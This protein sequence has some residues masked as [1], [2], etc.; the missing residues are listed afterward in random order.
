MTFIKDFLKENGMHSLPLAPF[1]GSRFNILFHNAGIVYFFHEKMVTFLKDH[2]SNQWVLHDLKISFFVAGCKALGLICKL[3]TSPLWNLI[4]KKDIHIMDMN[5][6][7]LQLTTFLNDASNNLDDFM[8]G[9]ILPFG[10]D[11]YVK[12]D[13]VYQKL[14]TPIEYDGETCTIL[15][16]ILPVIAKLTKNH[17]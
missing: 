6:F 4:E 11:T 13:N 14:I 15:S 17:F 12:R 9:N 8:S 2:G 16:I 10:V 5:K 1:K 3:V 7:Y